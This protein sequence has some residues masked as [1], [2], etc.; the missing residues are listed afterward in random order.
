MRI[1]KA[2]PIQNFTHQDYIRFNKN[3]LILL[4]KRCTGFFRT[5]YDGPSASQAIT[6]ETYGTAMASTNWRA[7]A[8]ISAKYCGV[9]AFFV[10]TN[11][12]PI[13]NPTAPAAL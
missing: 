9:M 2:V 5:R 3:P 13:P 4:F 7:L 8:V 12:L 6:L 11:A 10:S 1:L